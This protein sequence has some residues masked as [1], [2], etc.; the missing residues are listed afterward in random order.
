[1]VVKISVLVS[2]FL[3]VLLIGFMARTRWKLSLIHI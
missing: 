2:Y 1:M 3:V